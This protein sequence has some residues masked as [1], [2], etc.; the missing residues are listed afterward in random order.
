MYNE[1]KELGC[2]L[3]I[4]LLNVQ[5]KKNQWPGAYE[6]CFSFVHSYDHLDI[7]SLLHLHTQ[8]NYDNP[9]SSTK[10]KGLLNLFLTYDCC[11]HLL[12]KLHLHVCENISKGRSSYA[13][14][15]VAPMLNPFIYTLRNQQ[16]KQAFK[17]VVRRILASK[18]LI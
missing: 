12:W 16:V 6:L 7:N 2:C 5:N 8:N 1:L 18:T 10:K 4:P 11:L 14:Y 15:L 13:Q 9:L 17:D 3:L